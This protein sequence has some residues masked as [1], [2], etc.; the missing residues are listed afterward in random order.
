MQKILLVLCAFFIGISVVGCGSKIPTVP[1]DITI[2]YKGAP[3]EEALVTLDPKS[4][5]G[6]Q[7]TATGMTKADGKVT[8]LTAS[9]GKGAMPGD[10]KVIVMKTP[11][12]GSGGSQAEQ[13]TY[14]TYEEA[15]AAS[16]QT[17]GR[18][19]TIDA[20][21]QLPVKYASANT[22]PLEIIVEKG[23]KNEWTFDL[24]D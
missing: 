22:T 23:K 3:V 16:S 13:P 1:V 7:R 4:R 6:E 9:A 24:E 14:S 8:V 18:M 15:V 19:P 2:T 10:Y 5:G 11:L 21:H 20:K 12:I 17:S